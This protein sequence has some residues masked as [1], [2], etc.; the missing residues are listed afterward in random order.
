[1]II[2]PVEK[3]G[4]DHWSLLAYVETL[5]VDGK[6]GV[7]TID[8]RKMRCN[9]NIHPMQ[10]QNFNTSWKMNYGTRLKGFFESPFKSD[11]AKAI[12]AGE[13]VLDHDDWHCLDDLEAAGLVEILP[14]ANGFI[15]MTDKGNKIAARLRKHKSKG[16]MFANFVF[17]DIIRS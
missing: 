13:Q 17:L 7:G 8:G 12:E 16:G 4:K 14:V 9:G 3:F 11:C 15:K 6:S 1:L 10:M 5:C 2:I